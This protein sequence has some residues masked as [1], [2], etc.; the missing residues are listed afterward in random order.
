MW[1]H[2]GRAHRRVRYLDTLSPVAAGVAVRD[3]CSLVEE[4]LDV[5]PVAGSVALAR[6]ELERALARHAALEPEE[7]AHSI[8]HG[9][10]ERGDGRP[11]ELGGL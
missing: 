1:V 8:A 6:R 7:L 3:P 5:G 9:T 4:V 11:V 2:I 10:A